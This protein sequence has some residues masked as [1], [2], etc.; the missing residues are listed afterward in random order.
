MAHVVESI[1]PD[2]FE[3]P[4]V[5]ET[6]QYRIRPLVVDDVVKDYEAIATNLDRLDRL[7]GPDYTEPDDLSFHQDFL[8]VAWHH[9]EFQRRSSFAYGVWRLDESE[10]IG[11]V[12]VYP[13]DRGHFYAP[14]KPGFDAVVFLWTTQKAATEGLDDHL[15]QTVKRWIADVW[16]FDAVG[17]PGREPTWEEWEKLPSS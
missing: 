4:R 8:D 2:D 13:P 12:Y 16:P 6:N 10:G 14:P 15:F 5:F 1:V 17:F 11:G 9:K 3:L 7:M